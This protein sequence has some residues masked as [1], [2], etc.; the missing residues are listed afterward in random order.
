MTNRKVGYLLLIP[1]MILG[2]VLVTI[3]TQAVFSAASHLV[4]SEVLIGST[5][6]GEN[7]FIEIYN[8]M[9]TAVDISG[10]IVSRKTASADIASQSALATI[11]ASTE[12]KGHG[13]YL[14]AHQSYTGTTSADLIYADNSIA[15]NNTLYL[16]NNSGSVI[17][18]LGF[19]TTN[20]AENTAKGNP[21]TGASVERKANATST[22]TTLST[23]IDIFLGNGEDTDN[24]SSDFVNRT[25]PEPQN[26][27]SAV[28]T[29]LTTPIPSATSIS[30][31]TVSPSISP[32]AT[33]SSTP[34]PSA[35]TT[36]TTSPTMSPTSSP[37]V[38][39]TPTQTVAPTITPSPTITPNPI[40]TPK[41]SATVKPSMSPTPTATPRVFININ[42]GHRSRVCTVSYET[43][44]ILF[45]TIRIPRIDCYTVNH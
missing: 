8:P 41:P 35:S 17:D 25:N 39:P 43:R 11:P 33:S 1:S 2:L 5:G 34:M 3:N 38:A 45:L 18:K 42:L 44:K 31:P 13:Y 40:S 4:I 21:S 6:A 32:T 10:W 7:E 29:S 12:I 9:E 19:G 16:K 22:A 26:A 28:E 36:P 20:D 30:S 27:Q 23:G 37:S 15:S 14:I 24:N